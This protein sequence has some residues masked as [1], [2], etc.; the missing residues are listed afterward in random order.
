MAKIIKINNV[1]FRVNKIEIKTK[2]EEL[3]LRYEATEAVLDAYGFH[4]S[5]DVKVAQITEFLVEHHEEIES[6][7][8]LYKK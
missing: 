8:D 1:E 7:I 2:E 6:I 4:S 3:T 5:D